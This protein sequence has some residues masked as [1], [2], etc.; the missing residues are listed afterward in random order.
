VQ[1]IHVHRRNVARVNIKGIMR[2]K[3]V[4]GYRLPNQEG[5]ICKSICSGY[6]DMLN[7]TH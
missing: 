2:D 1:V 5:W 7:V 6:T 4:E 3:F